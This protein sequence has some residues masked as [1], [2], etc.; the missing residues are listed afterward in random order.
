MCKYLPS[1]LFENA[2]LGNL[3]MVA[4][5]CFFYYK[6]GVYWKICTVTKVFGC[7]ARAYFFK[8][9]VSRGS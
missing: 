4:R 7:I 3:K 5:K 9:R 8:C 6:P 1:K 2:V